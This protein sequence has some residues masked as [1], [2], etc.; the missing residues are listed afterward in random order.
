MSYLLIAIVTI[1]VSIIVLAILLNFGKILSFIIVNFIGKWASHNINTMI[2]ND[3][4]LRKTRDDYVYLNRAIFVRCTSKGPNFIK[5][6]SENMEDGRAYKLFRDMYIEN[7]NDFKED[8]R[9]HRVFE[10]M[11]EESN[12]EKSIRNNKVIH[13]NT[14]AQLKKDGI[15][16][17]EA[18]MEQIKQASQKAF[19]LEVSQNTKDFEFLYKEYQQKIK[20]N[21]SLDYMYEEYYKDI[22]EKNDSESEKKGE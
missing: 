15:N 10:K 22:K 16:P 17:G 7:Q 8:L 20:A 1:F 11:I 2:E 4:E 3:P 19:E 21:G 5:D 18:S 6:V 14:D 13:E 9:K 12:K